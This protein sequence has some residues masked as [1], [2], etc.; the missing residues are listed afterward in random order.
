[1]L[2]KQRY[3]F[4]FGLAWLFLLAG[5]NLPTPSQSIAIPTDLTVA[6]SAPIVHTPTATQITSTP[7]SANTQP[8]QRGRLATPGFKNEPIR[9]TLFFAGQARDGSIYYKCYAAPNLSLYT[10][11]PI[12]DRNLQWSENFAN[13]SYALGHML[14]AGLNVINMSSW[15]EDFLPCNTGWVPF[16]PMQT[17]PGAQDELFTAAVERHLLIIPFIESR[18]DWTFRDEFPRLE[19]GRLAPGTISQIVNL[20]NRYLN[21]PAHP[22]WARQWAQVYDRNLESRYA[23]SIIHASSNRL[24]PGNDKGFATGFTLLADA[25]YQS[26]G[27][28]V[29]FFIDP[30][31]PNSNAPGVFR[32]SPQKTGLELAQVDAI[33]GIQSFIPEIWVSGTPNTA[34]LIA[35]KQNFS[36]QWSETGIPFLMDISP[37]YD[38]HIVFPGSIRYGYTSQWLD[39]LSAMVSTFGQDGLI[40]NSWNGYTEGLVVVPSLEYGDQF[41]RWLQSACESLPVTGK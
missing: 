21:N 17:A 2:T 39:S 29:G 1:M 24:T 16:A 32:P 31:P 41:S 38:A 28:K 18:G 8:G 6:P 34:D 5:C 22:E 9:T 40:F 25:V 4:K 15:G 3:L 35:W 7:S 37:G 10:V 12:D 20:I 27:V 14:D 19:D 36:R 23:V 13:Q 30:L 11:H 26:T 33:L